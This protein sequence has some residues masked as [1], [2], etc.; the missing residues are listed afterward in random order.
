MSSR[1]TSGVA[2]S[3]DEKHQYELLYQAGDELY[4]KFSKSFFLTE[5]EANAWDEELNE[6]QEHAGRM[7]DGE[8]STN[9]YKDPKTR[10][11]IWSYRRRSDPQE[12]S[13]QE[14]MFLEKKSY[15]ENGALVLSRVDSDDFEDYKRY[16]DPDPMES[17]FVI[18][19]ITK[20][21]DLSDRFTFG[22]GLLP[23]TEKML[24]PSDEQ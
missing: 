10:N 20:P 19:T 5:A 9:C 14:L 12:M 6:Y 8:A 15:G 23:I 13:P 3:T 7:I 21:Y 17:G 16:I 2:P 1:V 4:F 22:Y 11:L 18:D 24:L